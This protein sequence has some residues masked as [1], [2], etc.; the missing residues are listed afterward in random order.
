M[1]HYIEDL[2]ANAENQER[3]LPAG[4]AHDGDDGVTK[5]VYTT[6]WKTYDGL[7]ASHRLHARYLSISASRCRSTSDTGLQ[8]CWCKV[9]PLKYG[10]INMENPGPDVSHLM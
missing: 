9:G 3:P 6:A 8:G 7:A 5:D 10:N 2:G 4:T 1:R